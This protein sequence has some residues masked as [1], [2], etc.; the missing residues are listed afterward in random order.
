[1][2]D[3]RINYDESRVPAYTLPD[4]LVMIGGAPVESAEIW[5][6]YR[7]PEILR[8]FEEY[9]YGRI[10]GKL[11][12]VTFEVTSVD[13]SALKGAATR[14]EVSV[15]FER[16]K[17]YPRIDLLV[18]LPNDRSGPVP[19]FEGLNFRGN[20][21]VCN[22][23]G[24]SATDQWM[25]YARESG[26]LAGKSVQEL[27]GSSASRWCVDKI[28]RRGYALATACY[29]DIDPD[30]DDGFQNGVHPL[31]Y[32]EG[33]TRPA[34]DEWGSISAWALGLSRIMD[35]LEADADINHRK[36]T[37]MGHSRLGKTALWAA[38]LDQRF[39]A[40]ISSCSGCGGAALSKRWFGETVEAINTSFPHWFCDNFKR[41]NGKEHLLPV[42]QHM[43]IALIAPRPVYISCAEDDLWA[44]SRGQFLAALAASPVYR[45]LGTD[46]L[47]VG[48]MPG[49]H[50]PVMSTIGYHIRAGKHDV[51]EYD[52]E[53]F[54]DFA[55]LRV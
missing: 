29:C 38:A 8:L 17:E 36:V 20:I 55:E 12:P 1:M 11:D 28:I 19:V 26:H 33:Q 25:E 47:G 54:I 44:D 6:E 35:Y 46:G 21:T 30:F 13:S 31:F 51:T 49:L 50:Q 39:A 34:T 16:G 22:D 3:K 5:R 48:E 15:F 52:W 43:L 53:R 18:Y 24:I 40:A 23:P 7:R 42:D 41:Y 9:V 4:P 27:R 2:S 45:L 37:V 10:P 32:R 14:K